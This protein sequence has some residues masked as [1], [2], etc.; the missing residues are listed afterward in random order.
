MKNMPKDIS[1]LTDT[2]IG[3]LTGYLLPLIIG[4]LVIAIVM[5]VVIKTTKIHS[6]IVKLIGAIAVL[7]WFVAYSKIYWG[8]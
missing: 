8:I 5:F 7:V 6:G 3:H 1:E 4:C 2:I